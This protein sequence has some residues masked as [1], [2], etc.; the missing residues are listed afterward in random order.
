M[1]ITGSTTGKS[2]ARLGKMRLGATRL[3]YYQPWFKVLINGIDQSGKVRIEG[4]TITQNLDGQPDT[5]TLR[6]SGMTPTKGQELK[7]YMGDTDVAHCLFAVHI[8]SVKTVYEGGLATNVAYDLACIDYTW[9]LND[10]KILKKYTSTSASAIVT[11]LASTYA[12]WITTTNVASG[13]ATLDEIT[14]TNE[15]VTDALDRIA[16]RVGGYWYLDCGKD[17]HF[18]TNEN[19]VA[20]PVTDA[21]PKGWQIDHLDVDLSQVRTRAIVRGGG[22]NA[23]ADVPAGATTLPV[24]DGVWYSASGGYVESGPQRITYT[25]KSTLDGQGCVTAGTPGSA[26][27][28][29]SAVQSA[30]GVASAYVPGSLTPGTYQYKITF[31]SAAGESSASSA[32]SAAISQV[33]RP[34]GGVGLTPTTGGSMAPS[35]TYAYAMTYGTASG[36]T[37]GPFIGTATLNASQNA[38]ALSTIQIS[39]DARVTKRRIYRQYGGVY[40]LVGTINDNTT[41][42]FTDTLADAALGAEIP[43]TN[44]AG[45]GKMDV[46]SIAIGATG[47][48]SRKVYRT[49][50]GDSTFKLLSTIADNTTTTLLDNT[51][52]ASLGVALGTPTIGASPGDATLRLSDLAK[53]PASGWVRVG[54]Q[55]IRYTGRSATSGEGDVTGVPPS[56]TSG[57]IT[58]IIPAG[59]MVTVEP[60]LTGVPASGAGAVVYPINTGD[61]INV[62]V[63]RN[64]TAAQT[65]LAG[66]LGTGDGVVEDFDQDG[67]LSIAECQNRGDAR[68][69]AFKDPISTLSGTTRDQTV[70][71]GRSVTFTVTN[72]P[73]SGTFKIQRVTLSELAIGGAQTYVFPTRRVEAS[74]K[75]FSLDDLLRQIRAIKAA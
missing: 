6:V 15:D 23:S 28:A 21:A 58:S 10:K 36:E 12:S 8:L 13:L 47:T 56:G 26:P 30:G 74:S 19:L 54:S 31:V 11:D 64:D 70:R 44:N 39:G 20:Q 27:S 25:G 29:P 22:S 72:P 41:T 40:R 67:R 1:P 18:F 65:A 68:L 49:A 59:T 52:D 38:V 51:A 33:N 17:L 43:A 42:T 24:V 46:A 61:Q 35:T 32:A 75:R 57:C 34:D 45:S 7:I 3:D 14:F 60:H 37:T 48:T 66:F 73:V 62:R 53:V 2:Y 71:A 50:V 9:R 55:V 69:T 4:A 63:E 16:A 5:A